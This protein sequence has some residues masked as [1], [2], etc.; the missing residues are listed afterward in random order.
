MLF[1]WCWLGG[2]LDF[3][4]LDSRGQWSGVRK[5]KGGDFVGER[6]G[7]LWGCG[8][9]RG[10]FGFA[11]DR[12]FAL[13][14]RA[15]DDSKNKQRQ[16][17]TTARKNNGQ[18]QYGD[19]GC[20]RMTSWNRQRQEQRQGPIRRFWLRQNDDSWGLRQNDEQEQAR[21]MSNAGILPH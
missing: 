11:Q 1:G 9:R 10:S 4:G 13:E 20:A 3:E 14:R 15:Q 18:G 19:S 12:L 2:F 5:S 6:G 7:G 21:A 8:V 16:E 17:R